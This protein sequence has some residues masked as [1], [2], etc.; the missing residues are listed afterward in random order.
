MSGVE[1]QTF[2]HML[3]NH[4]VNETK[5]SQEKVMTTLHTYHD[6]V[7]EKGAIEDAKMKHYM[8]T[9]EMPRMER[10]RAYDE[11]VHEKGRLRSIYIGAPN[12]AALREWLKVPIPEAVHKHGVSEPYIYTKNIVVK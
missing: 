11:Y 1:L 8:D 2:A 12:K 4:M 6:T 10:Q 3:M 5:T 7:V 9:I